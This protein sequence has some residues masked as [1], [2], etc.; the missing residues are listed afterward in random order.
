MLDFISNF[1]LRPRDQREHPLWDA[2][3]EKAPGP[4]RRDRSREGKGLR[5][6][7]LK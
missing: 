2:G 3:R 6:F 7:F 5:V 4:G 1:V